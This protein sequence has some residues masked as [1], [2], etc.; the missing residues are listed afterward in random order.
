VYQ[1]LT[2]YAHS[3]S[4]AKPSP[5][6]TK[7]RARSVQ[8]RLS[9]CHFIYSFCLFSAKRSEHKTNHFAVNL[10]MWSAVNRSRGGFSSNQWLYCSTFVPIS[11]ISAQKASNIHAI[12]KLAECWDANAGLRASCPNFQPKNDG[13]KVRHDFHYLAH[14]LI[15]GHFSLQKMH[16]RFLLLALETPA[17]EALRGEGNSSCPNLEPKIR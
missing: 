13:P 9:T 6:H 11:H 5:V 12:G 1:P 16:D 15:I 4:R 8:Q 17:L 10:H 7:K 14:F 3:A 2:K